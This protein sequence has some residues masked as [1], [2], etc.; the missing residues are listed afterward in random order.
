M[1]PCIATAA[2]SIIPDHPDLWS[3]IDWM[4]SNFPTKI[5]YLCFL[6]NRWTVQLTT[7]YQEAQ[8]I[9]ELNA[10]QRL[11]LERVNWE[12]KV[13]SFDKA[14]KE[15]HSHPEFYR[16]LGHNPFSYGFYAIVARTETPTKLRPLVEGPV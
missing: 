6:A 7:A 10:W 13:L 4:I 8:V 5:T 16:S 14:R 11:S 12:A 9:V 2:F 3:W 1:T 15:R